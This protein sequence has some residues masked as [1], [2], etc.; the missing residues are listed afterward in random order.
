MSPLPD[1]VTQAGNQLD[2]QQKKQLQNVTASEF[3]SPLPGSLPD[4]VTQAG[5]QLEIHNK[6]SS[7]KM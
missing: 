5:N 6:K 2:T 4:C 1:C 3:M 7:Y